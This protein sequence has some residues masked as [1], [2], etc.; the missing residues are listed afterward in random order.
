MRIIIISQYLSNTIKAATTL[1]K[2]SECPVNYTLFV[3]WYP[4]YIHVINEKERKALDAHFRSGK[5]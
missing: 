5:Q 3:T 2:I 4:L 1:K